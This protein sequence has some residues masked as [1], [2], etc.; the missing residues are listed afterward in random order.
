MSWKTN[1]AATS[2]EHKH[3]AAAAVF[4]NPTQSQPLSFGISTLEF[5]YIS[6]LS[7]VYFCV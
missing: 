5:T 7:H 6:L 4:P 2:A 1:L 3:T